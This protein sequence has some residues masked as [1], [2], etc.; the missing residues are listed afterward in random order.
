MALD[1]HPR[2]RHAQRRRSINHQPTD[3]LT[4]AARQTLHRGTRAL[5]RSRRQQHHQ[6][7]RAHR[8]HRVIQRSDPI[9]RRSLDVRARIEEQPHARHVPRAGGI[10]DRLDVPV[11]PLR[12]PDLARAVPAELAVHIGP[13]GDERRDDARVRVARGTRHMQR[14]SAARMHAREV[15]PSVDEQLHDLR[16]LPRAVHVPV[17]VGQ[18]PRVQVVRASDG[19]VQRGV[20]FAGAVA[21]TVAFVELGSV[22]QEQRYDARAVEVD[23]VREWRELLLLWPVA[24][25]VRVCA[26]GEQAPHDGLDPVRAE[27][28]Q[29]RVYVDVA[30]LAH[31]VVLPGERVD[32]GGEVCEGGGRTEEGEQAAGGEKRRDEERQL[33]REREESEG[34]RSRVGIESIEG[35]FDEGGVW[36]GEEAIGGSVG[37]PLRLHRC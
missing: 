31:R 26:F 15:R 24:D 5:V 1:Q 36:A 35:G 22:A 9:P 2:I 37:S 19:D 11:H 25:V 23:G 30:E 34:D 16:D 13:R 12:E 4:R 3:F 21:A 20:C 14:G 6:H 17:L 7:L 18:D 32:E 33:G 10:V 28:L 27:E 29:R 8:Q